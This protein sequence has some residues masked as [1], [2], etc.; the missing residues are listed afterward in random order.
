MTINYGELEERWRKAWNEAKVYEPE[1]NDNEP[2]FVT[3][4]FPYVNT[5]QHIGHLRTYGTADVYARYMRLRGKNVLFPMGFH[6]TGTPILAVAKRVLKGDKDIIDTLMDFDIPIEDI[7][8][9]SDPVFCAEY[10]MHMH[11][12]GF[13]ISGLSIDWRRKF[14][15][16]EPIFSKMV[17]WQFG[18]LNDAGMLKKGLHP[19]GWCRNENNAVGQHDTKGDAEPEIEALTAVKFKDRDTDAYFVCATYRPETIDGVTNI[20]VGEHIDY[21]IAEVG[22]SKCYLSKHAAEKLSFQKDVMVIGSIDA[23]ELLKRRAINPSNGETV[24]VLPGYFVE[25]NIGTGIVMSVPAHAPF[26]YVAL[27]NLKRKGYPVP[28][29]EY[30][31]VVEVHKDGQDADAIPALTQLE[32]IGKGKEFTDDIVEEATKN[33]YRLESRWGV[34]SYGK[35]KGKSEADAREL[36]K[37]DLVS[38]GGAFEMYDLANKVPVFCRCG[39]EVVVKL[40]DQWFINYGDA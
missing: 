9:M 40:V 1:P 14:I 4:A 28:A 33:L 5:P 18:K 10:I 39:T 31:K 15:S 29:M 35:Y 6:A 2:V 36:I 24:P 17:E 30:R 19:V 3:A 21:V 20:F 11:Q 26:D 16:I 7:K 32:M 23:G 13:V 12:E 34:I 38:T 8:K 22:G 37:T 25:H 27:E